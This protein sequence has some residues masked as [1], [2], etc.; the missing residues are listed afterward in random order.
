MGLGQTT[1][2]IKLEELPLT[3]TD[4]D[5]GQANIGWHLD[6]RVPVALIFTLVVYAVTFV[7]LIAQIRSD[8]S[9]NDK[10]I[11]DIVQTQKELGTHVN[12][13]DATLSRIETQIVGLRRDLG[14]FYEKIGE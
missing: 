5:G 4:H 1:L 6:K 3:M 10:R 7:W 9:Y 2:S 8:V 14:R 13:Q 12:A 11:V